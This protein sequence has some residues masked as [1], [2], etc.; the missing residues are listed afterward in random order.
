MDAQQMTRLRVALGDYPHSQPLKRGEIASPSIAFDFSEVQPVYKVFGAMVRERAFDVSEMAIVTYLQAKAHGKPLVLLPAVMMGRFQHHCMFYNAERGRIGPSDLPGRR[1][2]VRS[3]AQTTGAWLRGHL[4]NDF[5]IDLPSVQWVTFEDAHVA[6]FRDPAG[7][8]RAA[9]GKNMTKMLLEGD[10]D[11]AIF[12]AELP[13]DPRLR[14]V[15]ADPDA[16]ARKWH[17]QHGVVPINHMVVVTDELAKSNPAIV[18]EVFRML[19]EGKRAAGSP[20]PGGFE[21]NPF[22]FEACRPALKMIIEYCAQQRLIPRR[23]EVEELFDRTTR[24]LAS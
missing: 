2:G 19:L 16:V 3:Y 5:G 7:V 24:A 22:G 23:F 17:A 18:R 9:A 6:E 21:L 11:A 4:Q 1:V 10:L 14:S 20:K 13:A 12:G 8:E 15:I